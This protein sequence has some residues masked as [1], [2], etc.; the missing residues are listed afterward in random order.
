MF[1]LMSFLGIDDNVVI[2]P[3]VPHDLMVSEV[4]YSEALTKALE[5]NAHAKNIRRRQ[6]EAEY[7]VAKAIGDMRQINLYA[8][9]GYTGANNSITNVYRGLKDNQIVEI[10]MSIPILD[11][12]KRRGKVKVAESNR[13]VVESKLKK[14][15]IE[16]NQN[17][18]ILVERFNNQRE[19][20]RLAK[21]ADE[22]AQRRYD[23]NVKTFK[24]GKIST[25][26]LN[27]SQENKDNARQDETWRQATL[28]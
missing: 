17:L 15:S 22:I 16:F 18:F 24:I 11:W 25:L 19:Q 26:D 28:W 20:L 10:G 14:E 3:Q 1:Q 12:G 6:L 7:N 13:E 2:E 21:R 4:N 8:Q 23:S 27:D 9:V 5:N